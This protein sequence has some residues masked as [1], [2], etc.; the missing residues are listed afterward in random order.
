MN[1]WEYILTPA[2]P[3]LGP[4]ATLTIIAS[5]FV[6]LGGI[7]LVVVP[8]ELAHLS[9]MRSTR[10]VRA[11][12]SEAGPKERELRAELR[13]KVAAGISAW[14]GA[15]ILSLL[16][17]LLGTRGL[18]TR[19]LPTLVILALPLLAGY[20]V[21]YRLFFYPRY[22][23]VCR[24]IDTYKSYDRIAKKSKNKKAGNRAPGKEKISLLPVKA[25]LTT[26]LLPIAYY[27]LMVPFSIPPDVPA[28]NHDHLLHQS[29]MLVIALLGY[30]LG[31][32]VSLGE[33]LRPM[34]PWLKARPG[35]S[36]AR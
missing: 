30:S 31:L 18:E 8:K 36:G 1:L 9:A 29:G 19:F 33:D 20:I 7:A 16:L 26:L 10:H 25:L 22:L 5:V 15:L 35:E 11:E 27:L 14:S 3:S 23:E 17:R 21:V 13:V 28:Q 6:A 32:A 24:R 4:V 12:H 34:V 2:G